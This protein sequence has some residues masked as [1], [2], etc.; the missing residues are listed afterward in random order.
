MDKIPI[1]QELINRLP[2]FATAAMAPFVMLT[3]AYLLFNRHPPWWALAVSFLAA[4]SA[5]PGLFSLTIGR[6]LRYRRQRGV[7]A[8]QNVRVYA[9]DGRVIR[10][11]V[12]RRPEA[13]GNG[14]RHWY[15]VPLD[16]YVMSRG[17]EVILDAAPRDAVLHVPS[18]RHSYHLR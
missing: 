7:T 3:V 4:F 17:D 9:A 14:F 11:A 8:P 5:A 16:G 13:D 18:S 1:K 2:F 12:V 6:L 15:I 10:C